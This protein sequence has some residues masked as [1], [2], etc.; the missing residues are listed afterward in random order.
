[1]FRLKENTGC[2]AGEK[3]LPGGRRGL[4]PKSNASTQNTPQHEEARPSTQED[5]LP[6]PPPISIGD[7]GQADRV[8]AAGR[9]AD[10][11]SAAVERGKGLLS[12]MAAKDINAVSASFNSR[13]VKAGTLAPVQPGWTTAQL[14]QV[15]S[16]DFTPRIGSICFGML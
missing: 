13:F 8:A 1:M 11:V 4:L 10:S 2:H 16:G 7:G 3:P 6:P 14:E 5:A 15:R 9:Q 12:R